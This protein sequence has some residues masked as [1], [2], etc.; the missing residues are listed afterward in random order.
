MNL[1]VKY[2]ESK[3]NVYAELKLAEDNKKYQRE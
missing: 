3:P 2:E 1:L